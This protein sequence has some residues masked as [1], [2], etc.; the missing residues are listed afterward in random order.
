MI[1]KT[2][3]EN[4]SRKFQSSNTQMKQTNL[5]FWQRKTIQ[6]GTEYKEMKNN[7]KYDEKAS[8]G[9]QSSRI[10]MRQPDEL[11]MNLLKP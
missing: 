3:D 8:P 10:R 7:K 6:T 1:K 11:R 4:K 5:K 2:G 9:N